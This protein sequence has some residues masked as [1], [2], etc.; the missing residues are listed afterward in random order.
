MFEAIW[1]AG[2]AEYDELE[3][4]AWRWQSIDGAMM[5]APLA[6]EE[7]RPKP[8]IIEMGF[9]ASAF[10]IEVK[11]PISSESVKKL[12]D[13][14]LQSYTYTLCEFSGVRPDFVLIYPEA[15]HFFDYDFQKKYKGDERN[16]FRPEEVRMVRRIMQRANVGELVVSER[17]HYEIKFAASRYF[18]PIRGQTRIDNLGTTRR[19]GSR[20]LSA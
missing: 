5:K 8:H 18:D 1:R 7:V 9:R 14:V 11:S 16:K 15:Q 2:L 13:C 12:L 20:K 19:V 17:N 10:G 3:G 4:I 6:Q